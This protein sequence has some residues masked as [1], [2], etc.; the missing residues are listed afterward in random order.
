[1]ANCV[2]TIIVFEL[3]PRWEPELQRRFQGQS[4]RV[5]GCR[6]WKELSELVTPQS[7]NAVLI[8][9]PDDMAECLQWMGRLVARPK[10][11]PVVVLCS[12]EAADLE[13]TLRDVG[14][15]EVLIEETSGERLVRTCRRLLSSSS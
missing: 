12:R 2:W 6:S 3:Q 1:M 9:L 15:R 8:D 5:R 4:I 14:V 7:A 10:H 11:P 13:W